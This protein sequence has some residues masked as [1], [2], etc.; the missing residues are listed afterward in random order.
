M[1][2]D[3]SFHPFAAEAIEPSI[4][5]RFEQQARLA[6]QRVAVDATDGRL[7]YAELDHRATRIARSILAR[8]GD[9]LALLHSCSF[10]NSV[11][12][13]YA[14]LCGG[15]TLCPYDLAARAWKRSPRGSGT[16]GSPCCTQ[17]PPRTG[18]SSTR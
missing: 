8:L 15:A 6:P 14:A 17:R 7:T 11:R 10:S 16:S 12:H 1:S 9:R 3:I 2:D 18:A 5:A 13:L 4:P